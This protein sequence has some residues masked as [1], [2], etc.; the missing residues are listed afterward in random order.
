MVLLDGQV[1]LHLHLLS[2]FF[3]RLTELSRERWLL[4]GLKPAA[5]AVV[6]DPAGLPVDC[7]VR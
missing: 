4:F 5:V 3:A 6:P 7:P 2:F 1:H